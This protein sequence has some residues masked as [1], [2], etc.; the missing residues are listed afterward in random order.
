MH[1]KA[2]VANCEVKMKLIETKGCLGGL[3]IN[4]NGVLCTTG[5][6]LNHCLIIALFIYFNLNVSENTWIQHVKNIEFPH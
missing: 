4:L 1:H 2:M 6:P 3:E 5:G